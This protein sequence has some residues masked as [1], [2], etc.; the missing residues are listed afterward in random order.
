M[1]PWTFAD[2]DRRYTAFRVNQWMLDAR[3]ED[4]ELLQTVLDPGGI[5]VELTSGAHGEQCGWLAVRD[6][7]LRGLFAGWEF[8]GRAT[9]SVR[10]IGSDGGLEFSASIDGLSHPMAP[11]EECAVRA[12]FIGLFRGDFDEAGYRTQR[13][14]ES[15][16]AKPAPE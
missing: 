12:A 13:F 8:D 7:A 4:F 10:H 1:L 11:D 16:L 6:R 9:T 14:V 2:L 3:P 15:V 5:P